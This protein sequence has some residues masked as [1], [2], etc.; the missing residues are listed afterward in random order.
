MR[1]AAAVQ[2]PVVTTPCI[3]WLYRLRMKKLVLD[4]GRGAVKASPTLF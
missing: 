1:N 3:E 2:R 4:E